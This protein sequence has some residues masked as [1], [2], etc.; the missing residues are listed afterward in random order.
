[1][2]VKRTELKAVLTRLIGLL[3]VKDLQA[4]A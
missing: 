3:C 4:A 1:M 2:V